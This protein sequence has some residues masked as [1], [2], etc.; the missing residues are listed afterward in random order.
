MEMKLITVWGISYISDVTLKTSYCI[1][2]K[3]GSII[4][5][6]PANYTSKLNDRLIYFYQ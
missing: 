4:G 3:N 5:V 1:L 6:L 2:D